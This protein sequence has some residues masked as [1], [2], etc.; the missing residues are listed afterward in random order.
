MC[1]V[2]GCDPWEFFHERHHTARK[3]HT[4]CEC[5]RRIRRGE[6]Y[7]CSVGKGDGQ[8]DSFRTCAHCEAAARWLVQVCNGYLFCGVL[9]ELEEHFFEE[10]API[11][12]VKLGLL[13]AQ[14]RRQ[15]RSTRGRLASVP[16]WADEL[17]HETAMQLREIELIGKFDNQLR[18]LRLAS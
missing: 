8:F 5:R 11:R 12:S 13:I 6:R 2:E 16:T 3:D 18:R 9:E 1:R 15:W 7:R 4:C 10:G 17:G 14:M